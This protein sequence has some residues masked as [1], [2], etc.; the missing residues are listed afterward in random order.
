MNAEKTHE[1]AVSL[2]ENV[3]RDGREIEAEYPLVFGSVASGDIIAIEEGGDVRSA[4]TTLARDMVAD[5]HVLRAGLIGSVSTDPGFRRRGLATRVLLEAEERL[6]AQGC[7]FALLW[8]DQPAFYLA[9]G[10]R[11]MGVE[12]DFLIPA[13]MRKQLPRHEDVRVAQEGDAPAIHALYSEHAQRVDRAPIETEQLLRASG[14][15]VL[16]AESSGQMVAYAC[17]GRGEDL[18][19]V[20]HEW[21]GPSEAVLA[22]VRSHMEREMLR[23]EPGN[24][25]LMSPA[26][27]AELHAHLAELGCE[28]LVGILGFGKILNLEAAAEVLRGIAGKPAVALVESENGPSG[29]RITGTRSEVTVPRVELLNLLFPARGDRFHVERVERAAGIELDGL[30]LEPFAWGLDS[31]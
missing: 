25:F 6:E 12:I 9:R 16:V 4:C 10:W 26:R 30:P 19:H 22:L 14:V 8:A 15:E 1:R 7:L 18:Q 23:G 24:V 13:T 17:M 11:P 28:P 27:S 21:A 29:V 2:M 31:I 3:L 20:V 5:G